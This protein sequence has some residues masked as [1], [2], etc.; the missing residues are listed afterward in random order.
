MERKCAYQDKEVFLY[1]K[2]SSGNV[3]G[4]HAST[5]ILWIKQA[6]LYAVELCCQIMTH[7]RIVA[8]VHA[9]QKKKKEV[10]LHFWFSPHFI[11]NAHFNS[12]SE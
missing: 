9:S 4:I 5:N 2:N 7:C 12:S 8:D 1:N 6:T 11:T 10:P 3:K